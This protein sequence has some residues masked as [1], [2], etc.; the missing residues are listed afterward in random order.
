MIFYEDLALPAS[1]L[2]LYYGF[3]VTSNA[4][5][6][7]TLDNFYAIGASGSK[8]T[9]LSYEGDA[10]LDGSSAG[11]TN[12]EELSITSQSG[13]TT[14]LSGDGGQTG[15]NA[16]NSTIYDGLSGVNTIDIHGL[17][18]DTY[19][20]SPYISIADT[21]VTTNVDVGQ[22]LVISSAVLIKVPSNL[23]SGTVF[24]DVNYPGGD[25]RNNLVSSGVGIA[26]VTVE[27][28]DSL[29]SLVDT[30]VSDAV[31]DYAF[32][33]MADG[34]Y[35][36]RVVNGSVKSSRCTSFLCDSYP[37]QTFRAAYN[38]TSLA[39][40]VNE[41]GG[42][43]LAATA[44]AIAGTITNAQSISQ[45]V[46]ASAGVGNIDFGFNFNT[47][48]NTNASGQGSLDRFIINSNN[49]DETGLDI[50]ANSIFDPAPGEDTSIF[51]IPPTADPQGR[52]ADANFN[53]TYFDIALTN[54]LTTITS[55]NTHIDGRTQTA[56]AT[57]TN[58]GTI[59]AGGTTVGTSA[60]VL[61]NYDRP[62]IQVHTTA[63]DVF[64]VEAD[65][66]VIRNLA[67]YAT[68]NAAILQNSGSLLI[69]QNIVGLDANVSNV[70]I[71]INNGTAVIDGNYMRSVVNFA[72]GISG[73][74]STLIQN[75][76]FFEN[77]VGPCSDTIALNGGTGIVIQNNLI[78][79]T[80]GIGID[81]WNYT[82]PV[83]I[84]ENTIENSGQ[85][86]GDC[87]GSIENAG[88]R[89]YTSNSVISK[90]IIGNN[91]GPGL[92]ITGG[93]TTGNLITQNS[94]YGN[95]T[96]SPA[97]GIDI[98]VA[99]TGNPVGDGI[100]LNDNGDADTGPNG[101][102]NF[103]VFNGLPVMDGTDLVI[104]GWARPGAIIE[105][106][107]TDISEGSAIIGENQLGQSQD[108]GEGQTYLTTLVE[109]GGS[110]LSGAT[111]SYTDAD[112]NTDNTN[113]FE[114]R[115]PMPVGVNLYNK[116]TATATIGNSTSEFSSVALVD[117]DSDIDGVADSVDLDDD[118][119]GILDSK[120]GCLPESYDYSISNGN[121]QTIN[122]N[123]GADGT[124]LDVRRIDN[125][126]N[127]EINGVQLTSTE[128]EFHAPLRTVEFADGTYYGA[129]GI[130][131]VWSLTWSN[132]TNKDTPL[133]RLIVKPSGFVEIFGSKT[134]NGPL[135]PMVFV[136][137]LSINPILLNAV[138]NSFVVNQV[139]NGSTFLQGSLSSLVPDCLIDTDGDGLTDNLDFDS[140]G[141]GC[142]DADEG[143]V[144]QDADL[145]NNGFFG[146]GVP[147]VNPDG[148]VIG[149]SYAVPADGDANGIYDFLEIG[150]AATITTE[151][152]DQ[153]VFVNNTATFSVVV[154]NGGSYQWEESIDG[155]LVFTPITDT[156][157]YSGSQT[158]SL[159]INSAT[160]ADSGNLYRV[161]VAN[162]AFICDTGSISQQ[163][164][165]QVKVRTV[166]TNRRITHRVK[167][168]N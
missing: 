77:A 136:N 130:S 20:I 45:V 44:D 105:F 124:V 18:L 122:L 72:I 64:I 163:A 41:V 62:E 80:G 127:L 162:T 95:G 123:N 108:Y 93:T 6:T 118:N 149:A 81:G 52:T 87:S 145:D 26:G 100:T 24:E 91:G 84:S 154:T 22:D 151:P 152:T 128:I 11:S 158:A 161:T 133:I 30:A 71:V 25:G 42:A 126:F 73:G 21:Q 68:N 47:I 43:N 65:N 160:I 36:I 83:T 92:V 103:P 67:I 14:I 142:N 147:S 79:N 39:E 135:E 148:T 110:D 38:G 166:I 17:D 46:I 32:G 49:L 33:G 99:T 116:L 75:N 112:G 1:T 10:T 56:Y 153:A 141:D 102:V 57:D 66:T 167:K 19:N 59:G 120:E 78:A 15:N 117:L 7:F 27:L 96:T 86:G 9:F 109:G 101:V 35:S 74:T 76:D 2:N 40:V 70:G 144:D 137:G 16:Y 31:G 69:T 97:L 106:F 8:A 104:R 125:S 3:D 157:K 54:S 164:L 13:V 113:E 29:G 82:S 119:D 111:S 48:V 139:V 90:N 143:Y 61:P 129:G 12:P 5:T 168:N 58:T 23:I 132:A 51:M 89:L 55:N 107:L 98:D 138:T 4:G 150:T 134:F 34:T 114:F 60:I 165:L 156:A 88:V 115:I 140:D 28:Y 146:S 94:F 50:E 37:V 121:S 159:L 53:G 63:G 155:G 131:N 85:N